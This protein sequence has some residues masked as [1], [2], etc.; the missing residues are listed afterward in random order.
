[1][2]HVYQEMDTNAFCVSTEM[3]GIEKLKEM[4]IGKEYVLWTFCGKIDLLMLW[5]LHYI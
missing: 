2:Q 4:M 5:N 3:K 1:M